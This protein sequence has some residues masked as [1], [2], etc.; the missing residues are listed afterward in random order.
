L[1]SYL[2]A[3]SAIFSWAVKQKVVADNPCHGIERHTTESRERVLDDRE[4]CLTQGKAWCRPR[5]SCAARGKAA[6][7]GSSA[8][9]LAP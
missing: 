5:L 9:L 4:L 3:A 2:A 8:P 6:R 1:A 7:S